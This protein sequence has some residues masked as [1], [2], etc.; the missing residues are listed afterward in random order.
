MKKPSTIVKFITRTYDTWTLDD[1]Y[2]MYSS[3]HSVMH[4]CANNCRIHY[5]NIYI[6]HYNVFTISEGLFTNSYLILD[7]VN[8]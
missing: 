6:I 5:N 3:L 7:K 1:I 8:I 4:K 2:Y